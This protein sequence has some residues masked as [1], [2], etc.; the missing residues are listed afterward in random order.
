LTPLT[1]DGESAGVPAAGERPGLSVEVVDSLA[2]IDPR[3]WDS[4]AHDNVLTAHAWLRAIHTET[5][6]NIEPRYAIARDG[7]RVVGGAAFYICRPGARHFAPDHLMF[8]RARSRLDRAGVSFLPAMMLGPVRSIG[9]PLLVDET[10]DPDRREQIRGRLL[11]RVEAEARAEKLALHVPNM[12]A[13]EEATQRLLRRRG[14]LRTIQFPVSYL[15]IEWSSF[16]G[17]LDYLKSYSHNM[18]RNVRKEMRRC[19]KA[20]IVVRTIDDPVRHAPRIH[21]LADTH[22]RKL[23]GMELPYSSGFFS[24]LA[25]NLGDTV[26]HGAFRGDDLIGFSVLFQRKHIGY[27]PVLGIDTEKAGGAGLYFSICYYGPIADAIARGVK[28]MYVGKTNYHAKARRGCRTM[29]MSLYYRAAGPSRH[30][31]LRPWFA[32]HTGYMRR[33]VAPLRDL[34]RQRQ[35]NGE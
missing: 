26:F 11:D 20:G 24:F 19:R 35:Y 15:D 1:R 10:L 34:A 21:E 13:D 6:G 22:F 25:E 14:Y 16:D 32:A 30:L 28:R 27:L 33:K 2:G 4:L 12:P 29:P 7:D 17:Y 5:L 23:N 9:R 8:G 18:P 3:A 31:A